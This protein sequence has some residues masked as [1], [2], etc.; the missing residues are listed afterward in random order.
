MLESDAVAFSDGPASYRTLLQSLRAHV[1]GYVAKQ[2]LLPRQE[3]QELI[4]ANLL[5]ARWLA[6]AAAFLFL[7]LVTF[8]FLV[9]AIIA[10]WLPLWAA[11]L[12]TLGAFLVLGALC[13]FIGYR[14]LVLKGPERTIRSFKE[15]IAWVRTGLL[16]RSGS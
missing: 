3:I 4:A 14:K 16:G 15:T 12:I 5:A 11:A 13:G 10:I 6:L 1:R 2:L 8:V 9:V 7:V